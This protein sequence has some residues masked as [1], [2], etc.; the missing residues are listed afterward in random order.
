MNSALL[1][2][3][4]SQCRILI[5]DDCATSRMLEGFILRR[6]GY[7][8]LSASD[9]DEALKL[10]VDAAPDIVLLDLKMPGVDGLEVLKQFKRWACT[11][12]IPV[13]VVTSSGDPDARAEAAQSGCDGFLTKPVDAQALLRA[14]EETSARRAC[15]PRLS[16]PRPQD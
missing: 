9:G 15:A 11:R 3:T 5:V 4:T 14:V 1:P 6:G 8:I 2:A 7:E 12:E 16:K 13:I 10:A